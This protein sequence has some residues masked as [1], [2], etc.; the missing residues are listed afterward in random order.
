MCRTRSFADRSRSSSG[1][2]CG[3]PAYFDGTESGR[4]VLGTFWALPTSIREFEVRMPKSC[5]RLV[6][7]VISLSYRVKS[8]P[9]TRPGD[10]AK[11]VNS[12]SIPIHSPIATPMSTNAS[13]TQTVKAPQKVKRKKQSE[14]L[15]RP[16]MRSSQTIHS[17][18]SEHSFDLRR[19]QCRLTIRTRRRA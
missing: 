5:H 13:L 3:V 15:L 8:K 16:S 14:Y 7:L 11:H 2:R 9:I 4:H 17:I 19:C 6:S 18:F 12:I 10:T 1:E